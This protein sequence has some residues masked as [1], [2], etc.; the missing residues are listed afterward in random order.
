MNVLVLFLIQF[1][2][3]AFDNRHHY[4]NWQTTAV[5]PGIPKHGEFDVLFMGTS[6]CHTLRMFGNQER[7][8]SILSARTINFGSYDA[9]PLVNMTYYSYFLG[10]GNSARKVVYCI[11]PFVMY[12]DNFNRDWPFVQNEIFRVDFMVEMITSGMSPWAIHLYLRSKFTKSWAERT[13]LAVSED[14]AMVSFVDPERVGRRTKFLYQFGLNQDC[15]EDNARILETIVRT[16]T[17]NGSEV[18]FILLPTLMGKEI[19]T[20]QTLEVLAKLSRQYRVRVYNF[21]GAL[22][23][24]ALYHDLD[25]LNTAGV[26]KFTADYLRPVLNGT[27]PGFPSE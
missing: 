3:A 10:R 16:A 22:D 14:T 27:Y 7:V 9:G 23:S 12:S 4:E 19:G 24:P 21:E 26:M 15:F 20:E 5:L 13:P 1:G 18:I 2:L 17:S 11:D 8:E 6:R 25:H